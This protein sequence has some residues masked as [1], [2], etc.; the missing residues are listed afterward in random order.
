MIQQ[1]NYIFNFIGMDFEGYIIRKGNKH[2]AVLRD[3]ETLF[4]VSQIHNKLR[5]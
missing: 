2:E 1:F 4:A 3:K 5:F